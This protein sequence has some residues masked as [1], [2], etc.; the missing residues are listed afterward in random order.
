MVER[1]FPGS[2]VA[3]LGRRCACGLPHRASGWASAG[4]PPK[5]QSLVRVRTGPR[6]RTLS[7]RQL[8]WGLPRGASLRAVGP[9]DEN[10]SPARLTRRVASGCQSSGVAGDAFGKRGVDTATH[11]RRCSDEPGQQAAR[12]PRAVPLFIEW[13]SFATACTGPSEWRS[14]GHG[15][16]SQSATGGCPCELGGSA[17][18]SM[19]VVDFGRERG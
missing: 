13:V 9:G 18:S 1:E 16:R 14:A 4:V 19:P 17:P 7:R 12:A 11:A 5:A 2:A 8:F 3:E 6:W 10:P 15:D